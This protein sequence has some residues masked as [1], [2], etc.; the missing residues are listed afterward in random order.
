LSQLNNQIQPSNQVEMAVLDLSKFIEAMAY[1]SKLHSDQTRKGTNIPYL[2]HLLGV[3]TL[4]LE[5][6]GDTDLAVAALLHDAVEDQ[7][8]LDTL[9]TI[10][11][12]FGESV[13]SIV[14]GCSDSFTYP[15]P[16]WKERKK[17]YLSHLPTATPEVRLVSLADKLHN[18]RSI[19]RDLRENGIEIFDK[20]NGGKAGTMW[21]YYSLVSIFRETDK[22]FMVDELERVVQEI[23]KL[24]QN[25]G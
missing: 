7:G 6:G 25:P 13:A 2:T 5:S 15:K 23:H 9:Q 4:V 21:Y 24:A 11:D 3:A 10:Q 14:E 17:A 8:G 1:A 16:P 22:G 18:A 19:L 12:K 20:F